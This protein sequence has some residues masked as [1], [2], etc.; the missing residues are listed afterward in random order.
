MAVNNKE[1]SKEKSVMFSTHELQRIFHTTDQ[2]ILIPAAFVLHS[3]VSNSDLSIRTAEE[4]LASDLFPERIKDVIFRVKEQIWPT[5]VERPV[6]LSAEELY[7]FILYYTDVDRYKGDAVT[8][9]SLLKLSAQVL[10]IKQT[11]SVLDIGCGAISFF[12]SL[13]EDDMIAKFY[14]VDI[15]SSLIDIAYL[16]AYVLKQ[17]ILLENANIFDYNDRGRFSKIFSNYSFLPS[18]ADYSMRGFRNTTDEQFGLSEEAVQKASS[19]WLFNLKIVDLLTEDGKAVAIMRNGST[20]NRPDTKIRQFFVENGFIEAVI[21]LP[22]KLFS[23]FSISTTLIV[24]SKNNKGVRMIDA[25]ELY[26]KAG[27]VNVISPEYISE[28]VNLLKADGDCSVYKTNKEIADCEYVL[29]PSRYM[30]SA[31]QFSEGTPLKDFATISRGAQLKADAIEEMKSETPTGYRFITLSDISDGSV[32]YNDSQYITPIDNKLKKY[33]IGKNSI[34]ISKIGS[35]NFKSAVVTPESDEFILVNGNL[36]IIELD[37][38]KA[39]ANYI[40]A[41]L[42]SDSGRAI[43]DGLYTGTAMKTLP[44]KDLSE[45]MIPL[46][47]IE[48]QRIIGEKYAKTAQQ[49]FRLKTELAETSAEMRKIFDQNYQ[50]EQ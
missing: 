22:I 16:K 31:P 39:D 35:P 14:G 11:D 25:G 37:E 41:F 38:S 13:I 46:P 30:T 36:Y 47:A 21:T 12:I 4:F 44:V 18:N 33:C 27:R 49:V 2:A 17:N 6:N 15:N 23:S 24:L 1:L 20:W 32:T 9:D 29:N 34:V 45:V 8:P 19:D 40:Q 26:D 48:T 3:R 10:D 7:C 5:V 43:L 50:A 42:D 28:I